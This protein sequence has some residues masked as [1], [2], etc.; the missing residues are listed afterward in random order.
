LIPLRQFTH[1][2]DGVPATFARRY[3][4]D[5]H[6]P[7]NGSSVSGNNHFLTTGDTVEQF[8]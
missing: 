1:F 6:K 5:R 8:G 4:F 3:R 7:R 2:S